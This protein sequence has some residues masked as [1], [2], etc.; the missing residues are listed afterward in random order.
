MKITYKVVNA[1]G[2]LE[3]SFKEETLVQGF[4]E[5]EQLLGDEPDAIPR[6]V[7]LK[8]Y[9]NKNGLWGST[10]ENYFITDIQKTNEGEFWL[11]TKTI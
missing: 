3:H 8:D 2:S 5:M 10:Y 7:L 9:M 1:M 6:M 11:F 4:Q